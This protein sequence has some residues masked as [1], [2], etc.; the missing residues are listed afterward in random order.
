MTLK[1]FLKT[2][3]FKVNALAAVGITILLILFVILFLRIYTHHGDSVEIPELKGKSMD[4]VAN[5]LEDKD[6]RYEIQDSIYSP[7]LP[8]GT[9]LDQFPKPGMKVKQHRMIFI[10][11][12]AVSQE[13]IPMPQLTDISLRQAENLIE[14]AGLTA[15]SIQYKPSEFPNLVLEQRINGKVIAKGEL[16]PKGSRVDLVVGSS[17]EGSTIEL[18][19][20]LGLT[21]EDAK[22]KLEENSLSIGTITYD[23]SVTSE[24]QKAQAVIWKQSPDP[25]A[26][27]E[28]DRGSALDVWMTVDPSKIQENTE[29]DKP[30]NSF[31]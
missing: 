31:F 26:T 28:I 6:L 25:A 10:T 23:E 1:E 18:P 15:G 17:G 12:C 14:N 13:K 20:L 7:D 9:V 19:S 4:Q 24:D 27:T 8:P 3:T 16:V 5:I 29:K 11:L 22:L 30:D 21:L 2:R